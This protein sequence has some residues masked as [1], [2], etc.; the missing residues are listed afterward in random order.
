[1]LRRAFPDQRRKLIR[2]SFGLSHTHFRCKIHA[3]LL[4]KG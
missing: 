4:S 1:V 2:R 3:A